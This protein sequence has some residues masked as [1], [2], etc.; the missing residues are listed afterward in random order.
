MGLSYKIVPLTRK[1]KMIKNKDF[2]ITYFSNKDQKLITR[3]G[4]LT[5]S[6]KGFSNQRKTQFVLTIG[7]RL[8]MVLEQ[9]QVR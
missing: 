5:E 1:A 6:C 8:L 2:Y 3:L 7:I 9:L 4:T